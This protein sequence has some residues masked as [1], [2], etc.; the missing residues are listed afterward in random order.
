MS[1]AT[2]RPQAARSSRAAGCVP[3][4]FAHAT[5]AIAR[6]PIPPESRQCAARAKRKTQLRR[7]MPDILTGNRSCSTHR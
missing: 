4:F 6:S 5:S 3:S 2:P 7:W 1:I